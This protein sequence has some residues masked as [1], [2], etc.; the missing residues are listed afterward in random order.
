MR[1]KITDELW[2]ICFFYFVY[3]IVL[4]SIFLDSIGIHVCLLYR[5]EWQ[6]MEFVMQLCRCFDITFDEVSIIVKCVE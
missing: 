2:C 3:D 5:E 4:L 6:V 1:Y